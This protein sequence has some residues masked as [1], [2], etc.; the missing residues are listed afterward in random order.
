VDVSLVGA[1][2]TAQLRQTLK[3]ATL[4][5]PEKI[6]RALDDISSVD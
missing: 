6:A 4:E 2:S 5:L 1:S 3:G